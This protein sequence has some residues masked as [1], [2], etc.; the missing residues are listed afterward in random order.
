MAWHQTGP[1]PSTSNSFFILNSHPHCMQHRNAIGLNEKLFWFIWSAMKPSNSV[2]LFTKKY[3]ISNINIILCEWQVCSCINHKLY[4]GV[5]YS[6]NGRSIGW[7]LLIVG[8]L[9]SDIN[10]IASGERNVIALDIY[11]H[12]FVCKALHQWCT[13]AWHI[14]HR[15][16]DTLKASCIHNN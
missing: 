6:T 7:P 9:P 16:I 1:Q 10:I 14:Y 13:V 5:H 3:T 4:P 15:I 8:P 11:P 2:R 12:W